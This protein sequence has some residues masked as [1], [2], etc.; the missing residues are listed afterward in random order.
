[1]S[2]LKLPVDYKAI[3]VFGDNT[4]DKLIGTLLILGGLAVLFL[5]PPVIQIVAA[6]MIIGAFAS[7]FFA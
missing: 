3:L 1:M 4:V 2:I 6:L 7:M 5:A